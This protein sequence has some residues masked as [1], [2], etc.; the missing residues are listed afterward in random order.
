MNQGPRVFLSHSTK[1]DFP[2][3]VRERLAEA[4]RDAGYRVLLDKD[5]LQADD[6]WHSS[7]ELWMGTCDAAIVLMSEAAIQSN[8]VA[9][10]VS[11]LGFRERWQ[12]NP[13]FVLIPVYLQP[14]SPGDVSMG[15]L[16][17][18]LLDHVNGIQ[19]GQQAGTTPATE[20][21]L[22]ID[23]GIAKIL[24]TL[25][26]AVELE[27]PL[28]KK[29][30]ELAD[31]L[32]PAS[33]NELETAAENLQIHFDEAWIPAGGDEH[34]RLARKV[35]CALVAA[36][37]NEAFEALYTLRQRLRTPNVGGAVAAVHQAL[38]L[39]A[40]AWVSAQSAGQIQN[41]LVSAALAYSSDCRRPLTGE[42]YVVR[43]CTQPLVRGN[44]WSVIAIDGV[45]GEDTE[46]ELIRSIRRG[47]ANE[48]NVGDDDLDRKLARLARRESIQIFVT[49]PST[50][51]DARILSRLRQTFPGVSFFLLA[52]A[53]EPDETLCGGEVTQ[54][55]PPLADRT[56]VANRGE[57][58]VDEDTFETLYLDAR[59]DLLE[60]WEDSR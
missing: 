40:S 20:R 59:D 53:N 36:P 28:E 49:L 51:L 44:R 19:I 14:I 43:A 48:L 16:A 5:G 35:A 7:L 12:T 8:F 60:G 57:P 15:P 30:D 42:M 33:F 22:D 32:S 25:D 47:L 6:P 45:V 17:P 39:V 52:G 3:Q 18:T 56:C 26:N 10:E 58:P 21:V 4:L 27:S 1:E 11:V 2:S 38:D 41:G 9:H 50:G 23:Q 55:G 37:F 54:L 31:L 46:G 24:K 29:L 34:A 13:Q